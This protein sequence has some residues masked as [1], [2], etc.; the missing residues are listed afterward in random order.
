[1]ILKGK[2]GDGDRSASKKKSFLKDKK[3]LGIKNHTTQQSK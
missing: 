2:L 1:M 3:A